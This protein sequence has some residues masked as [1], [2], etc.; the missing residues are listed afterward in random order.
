MLM[1]GAAEEEEKA[2]SPF[3][4]FAGW[5]RQLLCSSSVNV[6]RETSYSMRTETSGGLNINS[7]QNQP[8]S[9]V[10][11]NWNFLLVFF[12]ARCCSISGLSLPSRCF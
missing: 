3:I 4:S 10:S 11:T 9:V 5:F 1:G 7:D 2:A 8:S 12:S 6:A